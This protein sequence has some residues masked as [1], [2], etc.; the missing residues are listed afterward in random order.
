MK[1][2]TRLRAIGAAATMAVLATLAMGSAAVAAP[3]YATDATL[4]SVE[5]T[6]STVASGSEAELSGTWSLPDGAATPAGFVVPLPA[7]LQ[8]LTDAFPLLDSSGVTMGDCVVTATEIVCDLDSDYLAAHPNNVS[9]TFFFWVEVQTSV[10]EDTETTYNFGDTSTTVTVTPNPD[11]CIENCE[12][13]GEPTI[14]WGEYNRDD[15]TIMWFVRVSSDAD[16]ATAGQQMRVEDAIGPNQTMLTEYNGNTYPMLM[17]A[18]G[19]EDWNGWEVPGPMLEAP[20]ADYTVDGSTVSWTADEGYFYTVLYVAQ[21]TDGGAAGTYTNSADSFVDGQQESVSAEAQRQGGGGTG[22]GDAVGTFSIVKDVVWNSEPIIDLTFEGT[23]TVE[24]PDGA[25]TEGTFTVADGDVWTSQEFE[26]GSTV[27]LEEFLPTTPAN[28]DWEVPVFSQNDFAIVGAEDTQV[29]LT[30]EAAVAQGAFSAN[31]VVDGDAADLAEG[32]TFY[33]DYTYPAGD[34]FAAGSGV[35]ELPANG[36]VVNSDSI[37]VGAVLTLTERAPEEI[38][39]ANWTAS[40]LS[41]STVT[42]NRDEIVNVTVTNTLIAE[43]P[44][45]GV[46]AASKV[47]DG[48]AAELA[49]GMSF[50]LEYTYPAGDGFEAGSG[51][52]ELPADGTVVVSEELPVGAVLTL[53]EQTPEAVEGA[54]WSEP[55]LSAS[56]VTIASDG[57]VSVTVTNTLTADVIEVPKPVETDDEL[58]VTGAAAPMI[59]LTV[60]LLLLAGGAVALRRRVA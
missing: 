56:T 7:G 20:A 48:D 39:G 16:G 18:N 24:A 46:F 4:T 37:P 6:E 52:L 26:T 36:D 30:N 1:S 28:I 9:G 2:I 10:T 59:A 50:F 15:N 42:I 53:S 41:E 23:Y 22:D 19:F 49:D 43:V 13:D 14:K 3:P 8:G 40:S 25:V 34:G 33:L 55:Q 58:A 60:A 51:V 31:K 47:V 11:L 12:W 54:T 44:T 45:V 5:F 57:I 27:H 32:V 38:E 35:L 17:R 29:T 21:V